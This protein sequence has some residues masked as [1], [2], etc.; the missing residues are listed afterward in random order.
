MGDDPH[1][2]TEHLPQPPGVIVMSVAQDDSFDLLEVHPE[3]PGVP[4]YG[5]SLSRVKEDAPALPLDVNA[6]AVFP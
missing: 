1:P 6:Q 3:Q 2:F 5:Q 4:P